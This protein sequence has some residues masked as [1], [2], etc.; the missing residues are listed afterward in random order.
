MAKLFCSD[1]DSGPLVPNPVKSISV[2]GQEYVNA[3]AKFWPNLIEEV[4]HD[5]P[6]CTTVELS[7]LMSSR[8]HEDM[9]YPERSLERDMAELESMT[10]DDVIRETLAEMQLLG[11]PPRVQARLLQ[12]DEVLYNSELPPE[13]VDA[14]ILTYLLAWL[15]HWSGVDASRWNRDQIGGA[16]T[17]H[18]RTRGIT[19]RISFVLVSE[20]VKEGLFRKTLRLSPD[21]FIAEGAKDRS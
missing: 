16:L 5:Y 18:D 6:G 2:N 10:L 19:Y 8:F 15:L 11:E 17:A 21:R 1:P 9:M 3:A 13:S 14:E 20:H 7:S 12:D 4:S